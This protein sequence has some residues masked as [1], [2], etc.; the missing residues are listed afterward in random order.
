MAT[1]K[2]RA[3]KKTKARSTPKKQAVWLLPVCSALIFPCLFVALKKDSISNALGLTPIATPTTPAVNPEP[4]NVEVCES[5]AVECFSEEK[6][7]NLETEISLEEA[8][9]EIPLSSHAVLNYDKLLAFNNDDTMPTES[10]QYA[11]SSNAT[12]SRS[13]ESTPKKHNSSLQIGGDYTYMTL[14]PGS[15]S[16]FHANLGGAQASY[17]YRPLNHFYGALTFDWKEGS[18]SSGS[19]TRSLLYFDVQEKLGYTLGNKKEDLFISLF[20]GFGYRYL[21]QTLDQPGESSLSFGYNEFYFP[22]GFA[23]SFD[24]ASCFAIGAS[25]SWMPQVYSNVSIDPLKGASWKLTNQLANLRAEIPFT[26]TFTQSRSLQLLIKP[27]YEYWQDGHST[28]KLSSGIPL[29][30]PSNTY[31]FYGVNVNFGYCF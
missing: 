31:N 18:A 25:F 26:F 13:E 11:F 15:G 4:L 6:S 20:S 17:E 14:K 22:L 19:A 5:L 7:C 1:A 28:A 2:K 24:L 12:P 23:S 3:K 30:L 29:G 9:Q 21:G 10:V 27:F 16:S 8:R